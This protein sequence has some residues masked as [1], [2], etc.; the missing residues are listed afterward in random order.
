ML[1]MHLLC[2]YFIK[3]TRKDNNMSDNAPKYIKLTDAEC[4][5]FRSVRLSFNNMVRVIHESGYNKGKANADKEKAEAMKP[6]RLYCEKFKNTG[7]I[8]MAYADAVEKYDAMEAA[9]KEALRIAD[10]GK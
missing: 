6:L 5:D 7:N 4:D 9:I 3:I 1:G 2:V 8:P 10:K